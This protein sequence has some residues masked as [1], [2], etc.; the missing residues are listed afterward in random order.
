MLI[1][2]RQSD[3][4]AGNA[5]AGGSPNALSAQM[6]TQIDLLRSQRVLRRAI[7]TLKLGDDPALDYRNRWTRETG[8]QGDFS[9]W[10]ADQLLANLDV[11]PTRDSGVLTLSYLASDRDTAARIANGLTQA[12]IDTELEMRLERAGK[13]SGF[14]DERAKALRAEVEAAQTRLS[15]YQRGNGVVAGASDR[16]DIEN[17]RLVE[18]SSQVA[19]VEALAAESRSRE[20]QAQSQG[21]RLPDVI[22]NPLLQS[23]HADLSRQQTRLSELGSRLGDQNPQVIEAAAGIAA[24]RSRIEQESRRVTAGVGVSNSV[25]EARIRQARGAVAEQRERVLRLK[26][27][28]DQV[29]VLQRDVQNAQRNYDAVLAQAGRTQLESQAALSSIAVIQRAVPPAKRAFPKTMTNLMIAGLFGI[30][31]ALAWVLLREKARMRLRSES[32]VVDLLGRRLLVVLPARRRRLAGLRLR[33]RR[34]TAVTRLPAAAA[35]R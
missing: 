23:L 18:L 25:N 3:L 20:A 24:L 28:Q 9:A 21:D 31:L 26:S 12:Y 13:F 27:G 1:D 11:R 22:N 6:S 4:L 10:V 19:A 15:A 34:S 7:D 33:L 14:F 32:D 35:A 2:T 29:A 30:V 16:L 8:A 17:A 5:N